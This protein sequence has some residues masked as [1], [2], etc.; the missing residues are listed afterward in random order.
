MSDVHTV[1]FPACLQL[2]STNSAAAGRGGESVVLVAS[3][4]LD[5]PTDGRCNRDK[6]TVENAVN[7]HCCAGR[8]SYLYRDARD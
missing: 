1:V 7:Y 4:V 8:R 6:V 2:R 5:R 3:C